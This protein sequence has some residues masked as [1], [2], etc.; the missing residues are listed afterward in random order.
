MDWPKAPVADWR[1]VPG[2]RGRRR[3]VAIAVGGAFGTSPSLAAAG[4]LGVTLGGRATETGYGV[5]YHVEIFLLFLT[6]IAIGPLVRRRREMPE[7][8]R[9]FGWRSF[10]D[11]HGDK[12]DR[13]TGA[14]DYIDTAQI[15][16]YLFFFFAGLIFYIRR[17][18]RRKASR[19]VDPDGKTLDHGLFYVPPPRPSRCMTARRSAPDAARTDTRKILG[20]HV[21]PGPVLRSNRML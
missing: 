3:R 21:G 8:D 18:D 2:G 6:L 10:L 12:E 5:V 1:W 19:S 14:V 16:L 9:Q 4:S 7:G 11:D 13:S 20:A 17:E 15:V